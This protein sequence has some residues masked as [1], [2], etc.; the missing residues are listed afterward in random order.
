MNYKNLNIEHYPY[1][2]IYFKIQRIYICYHRPPLMYGMNLIYFPRSSY[3]FKVKMNWGVHYFSLMKMN[4][5]SM[6]YYIICLYYYIISICE[7]ESIGL[8]GHI[9]D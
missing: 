1:I 2:S 4:G 7:K 5:D 9:R 8:I 6:H 3:L